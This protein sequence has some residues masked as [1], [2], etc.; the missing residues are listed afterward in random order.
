MRMHIDPARKYIF[1]RRIDRLARI[2]ARKT[3]SDGS[4]FASADRNV[5]RECVRCGDHAPISDEGVKA[6][7]DAFSFKQRRC[8]F[9]LN[10]PTS[11]LDFEREPS[12]SKESHEVRHHDQA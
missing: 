9:M 10:S 7:D 12:G 3:L 11:T 5:A 2:F 1:A 8:D 6:H 4:D